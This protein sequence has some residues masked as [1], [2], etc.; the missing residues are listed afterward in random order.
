[1]KQQVLTQTTR[2]FIFK[3]LFFTY[4]IHGVADAEELKF[5][6][7]ETTTR[8]IAENAAVGTNVGD[9]LTF[10][11]NIC[12][13][14]RLHGPDAG[15]LYIQGNCI[16][17]PRP[18]ASL[19]NLTTLDIDVPEDSAPA[20]H[21]NII[22]RLLDPAVLETLNREVLQARL[23]ELQA[24][25]DGSPKYQQAIALLES[26]L[27]SIRP[28]KTTLLPNY[29]NP[30]NPET[31]IPYRL[32]RTTDVQI[33]IYNA[34]GIAVRHLELGHQSTGYYT[35]R[36]RAAYW[37]G[38]ND[39]GERVTSGI[40]FYQLQADTISPLRRMVTLK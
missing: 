33:T 23:Q 19:M 12:R 35:S 36:N 39:F 11:N 31:W 15:S 27:V 30:F 1:M 5:I 10:S 32:A 8:E 17:S 7:G 37:D 22:S 21:G 29:P 13:R 34:H 26:V 38:K 25:S 18:L 6:E 4:V 40:Y 14:F 2:V 28:D 9:P 24:E 16:D 20:M 3:A